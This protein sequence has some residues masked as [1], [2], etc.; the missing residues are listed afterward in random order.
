MLTWGL[1]YTTIK[2][3]DKVP[4]EITGKTFFGTL[5]SM[6][7]LLAGMMVYL[8]GGV[9]DRLDRVEARLGDRLDRIEERLGDRIT[10]VETRLDDLDQRLSRIEGWAF[11]MTPP[12]KKHQ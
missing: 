10:G 6:T 8:I 3:T 1:I 7:A 2:S 5:A 4:A 12:E 11:G 9:N